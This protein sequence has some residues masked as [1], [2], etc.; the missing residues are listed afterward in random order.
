MLQS[1]LVTA[2]E[3]SF[4]V[5][6]KTEAMKWLGKSLEMHFPGLPVI[7]NDPDF[8][9]LRREPKFKEILKKM[10]LSEY[11]H[12]VPPAHSAFKQN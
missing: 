6:E 12:P 8:E 10:G 11:S 1:D 4:K 2:A 7:N 3:I 9:C 5:G